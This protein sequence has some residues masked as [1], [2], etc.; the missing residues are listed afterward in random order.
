MTKQYIKKIIKKEFQE[1]GREYKDCNWKEYG[2]DEDQAEVY[3]RGW[4]DAYRSIL[5]MLE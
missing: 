5:S 3:N 4:H 1:I 2:I